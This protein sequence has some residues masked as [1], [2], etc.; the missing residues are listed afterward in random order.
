MTTGL[1]FNVGALTG[2]AGTLL[3]VPLFLLLLLLVRGLP[4]L[5]YRQLVGNR[6]AVVAGLLQATSL[7]F[8]AVTTV[9]GRELDQMTEAN[10][11]ALL[12]AGLLSVVLFPALGLAALER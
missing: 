8:I 3:C 10:A 12:A 4:S 7:T 11:S 1:N 2:S 5:V 6:K 9:I